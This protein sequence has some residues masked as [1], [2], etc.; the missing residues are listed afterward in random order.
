ML[1]KGINELNKNFTS[2]KGSGITLTNNK[3]KVNRKLIKSFEKRGIL[4]K[5]TTVKITSQEEG[6]LRPLMTVGLPLV[7]S[8]LIQLARSAFLPLG[9][10]SGISG[11]NAAIQRKINGSSRTTALIISNEEMG[12]VMKIVKSLEESRLLK[13]G[14][15]E[16]I[17]NEPKEQKDR[18]LPML[19]VTLAASILGSALRRRGVIRAGGGLNF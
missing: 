18:F 8:V 16:T 5:E 4:L 14:I 17:K 1:K 12:D 11:A 6:F 13:K 15:S 3:V 19:L 2:S 9:L 10:S 7:E